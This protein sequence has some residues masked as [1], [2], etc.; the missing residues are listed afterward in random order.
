MEFADISTYLGHGFLY[1]ERKGK[2][3]YTVER[4][5]VMREHN[6]QK[7]T[8]AIW[9]NMCGKEIR[10]EQGIVKEGC[11]Y[12]DQS[13]GYFSSKDGIRHQFDLCESCY[14]KMIQ[15]FVI[16]VTETE[17]TEMI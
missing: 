1:N 7:Q 12:A 8:A 10:Q 15:S 16:P 11:F 6:E 13:W 14:D 3:D 5:V 2:L 17:N 4:R 9:C